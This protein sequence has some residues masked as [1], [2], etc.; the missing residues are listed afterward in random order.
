MSSDTKKLKDPSADVFVKKPKNPS[1]DAPSTRPK[2]PSANNLPTEGYVL[3]IDGKF[4]S[5]YATSDEASKAGLE[6]KKKFSNIQIN[7]YD[8]KKRTRTLIEL[9]D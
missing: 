5:E 7:V 9:S 3:E 4:K 1:A 6:L 2:N 8:A